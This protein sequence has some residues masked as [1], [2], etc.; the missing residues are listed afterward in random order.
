MT[1]LDEGS[2]HRRYLYLIAY[3]SHKRQTSTLAA[4]FEP[5]T[6][7]CERRQTH[8]S[9]HGRLFVVSVVC[10][11]VVDYVLGRSLVKRSPTECGVSERD[12]EG[13]ITRKPCPTRGCCVMKKNRQSCPRREGIVSGD[14]P[15]Y[16]KPPPQ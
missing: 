14:W 6:P 5:T 8:L 9:G 2:A 12:C 3:S 16:S 4:G 13:S 10:C 11:Q 7:A 1:A 15:S